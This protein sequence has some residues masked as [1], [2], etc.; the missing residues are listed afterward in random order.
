MK[1]T[2]VFYY[3]TCCVWTLHAFYSPRDDVIEI[4]PKNIDSVVYDTNQL[5]VMEFYAPWCGH[6]QKLVPTWKKVASNLKGLVT[7][8]AIN[9]D[10]DKN[11]GICGQYQ[12]QGFPTIKV[13]STEKRVDKRTGKAT[14]SATDYQGPR[15]A[16][17]LVDYLLS[18]QP[19]EVR[20]LKK[21]SKDVKSKKSMTLDQFYQFKNESMPKV[22][23]FTHKPSTT[24][25][26][27]AVSV[28]FKNKVLFGEVKQSEKKLVTELGIES[29]PTLL[30]IPPQASPV[31]FDTK[32][33]KLNSQS[34]KAFIQPYVNPLEDT[35]EPAK[36]TQEPVDQVLSIDTESQFKAHCPKLCLIAVTDT[37]NK[38]DVISTLHDLPIPSAYL[39]ASSPLVST[40]H[41]LLDL[42]DDIPSFFLIHP[43]KQVY[44]PYLGAMDTKKI[45]HW[46]KQVE[47]GHIPTWHY[48]PIRDEL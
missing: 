10:E 39:D 26:Y 4:T 17:S 37:E 34:L 44:R 46:L 9:C 14:K 6:C 31:V 32:K 16:K 33:T 11:K 8:T 1:W 30:L 19:S 3:L 5:V 41:S 20:Y 36:S 22:L 27:K 47:S 15:E 29:F 7:V 13:F 21:D 48:R 25:L 42:S 18:L 24:P 28:E 12:I 23:L 38:P 2:R 40:F 35:Q 43:I 45:S